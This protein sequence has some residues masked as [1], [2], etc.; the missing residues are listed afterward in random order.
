MRQRQALVTRVMQMRRSA[1]DEADG[2]PA[3]ADPRAETAPA[4]GLEARVAYLENLV[5]GLQDSVYRE[6]TRNSQRLAELE[7]RIEPAALAVA[8]SQ[9]ARQRGI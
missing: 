7:A 9:D 2:R 5:Q 4:E 3:D 1:A 8:L 6:A